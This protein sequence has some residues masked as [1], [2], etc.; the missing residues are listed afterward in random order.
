MFRFS[1]LVL[2]LLFVVAPL[3]PGCGQTPP[4]SVDPVKVAE[5]ALEETVE[6]PAQGNGPFTVTQ[7]LPEAYTPAAA[8]TASVTMNYEGTE[9]V[10]ALALQLKLPLGW[11]FDT[12]ETG[13]KPAIEPKA[14]AT[15]TLTLVWITAPAFPATLSYTV[16]VP[17]WA[18]GTLTMEA[19]AIYRTLGDELQSP[20]S[21]AQT[22]SGS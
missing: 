20:V 19:Q 4:A 14:G 7:T 9:P 18:E 16:Q 3:I 13:P 15:D 6:T 17:D 8:M 12:L 11:Q 1:Y 22:K 21:T 2:C 10:T 5:D